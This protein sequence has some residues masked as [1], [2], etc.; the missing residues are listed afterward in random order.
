M[1]LTDAD[2]RAR[3][4]AMGEQGEDRLDI[5]EAALLLANL[6]LPGNSMMDYRRQLDRITADLS[7]GDTLARRIS[8]LSD[9]LYIQHGFTGDRETYDDPANANLMQ[10][11]DRRKGLPVA[12]GI[13]AIHVGRAQGWDIAGLNFP[14]HFLLGIS[15]GDE[16]AYMDPFDA[17]RPLTEGDLRDILHRVHRQPTELEPGFTQLVSDRD[18][19]MR[20]QNNIKIRALGMGNRE[21]ALEVL[22]SITLIAPGSFETLAELAMLEA[23]GGSIKS[24]LARLDGFLRRYPDTPHG[25]K[26]QGMKE[27]LN[28]SLN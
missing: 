2:I 24:A 10:V 20:L 15:E 22:Q 11:I 23:Q 17:L 8:A 28:R 27:S 18:I 12:L 9:T 13:L 3:L 16:H 7:G 5:G 19:L 6:D 26:I 4:L 25:A 1:D 21:R 14:G